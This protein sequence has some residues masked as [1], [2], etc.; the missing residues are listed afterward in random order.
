[1]QSPPLSP[2]R[3]TR[4]K[5][6]VSLISPWRQQ[7][8]LLTIHRCRVTDDYGLPPM[9]AY[10]ILRE[11]LIALYRSTVQEHA[12][13]Y[14]IGDI[15]RYLRTYFRFRARGGQKTSAHREAPMGRRRK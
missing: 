8:F 6:G 3:H 9:R 7:L 5:T 14:I 13:L 15:R 1:M 4:A 2:H 12:P 10:S 11:F